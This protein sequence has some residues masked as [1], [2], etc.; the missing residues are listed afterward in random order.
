MKEAIGNWPDE[1]G[2]SHA[3]NGWME[4]KKNRDQS[5]WEV[6]EYATREFASQRKKREGRV[7]KIDRAVG[8]SSLCLV[9]MWTGIWAR[10]TIH[11][12]R[13]TYSMPSPQSNGCKCT[14]NKGLSRCLIQIELVGMCLWIYVHFFSF[15][16]N[17]N[18]FIFLKKWAERTAL[19]Q[20]T[21]WI[22]SHAPLP[23]FI[24]RLG[25]PESL[26]CE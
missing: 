7:S 1:R 20:K 22:R 23:S 26:D 2:Q 5:E 3:K 24:T 6:E 10:M 25:E 14:I 19:D 18:W 15:S 11:H 17:L 9:S 21:S 16:S 13:T 8:S 4:I 12:W